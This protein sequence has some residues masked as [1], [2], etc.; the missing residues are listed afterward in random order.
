VFHGL[1]ELRLKECDR[2]C[3]IAEGLQAC[4][5]VA[6]IDGE[7]LRVTGGSVAGGSVATHGDHRIAMAFLVLGL[8]AEGPVSVDRAEM[9][10]TSFPSFVAAMQGIGVRIEES[11]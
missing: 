3:A 5:V 11:A 10:A 2:V 7:T 4:G 8:G 9:I 1:G 6:E